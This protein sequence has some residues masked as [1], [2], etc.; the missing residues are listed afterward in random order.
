[1]LGRIG[2]GV[3]LALS[4]ILIFIL[5]GC[6][7]SAS[8]TSAVVV[9]PTETA[10]P[11]ATAT[12][13]PTELPTATPTPAP[14]K[15]VF[16]VDA[17]KDLGPISKLVLGTNH[18]PWSDLGVGNLDPA[19]ASGITF[20]RWPGGNWGDRNDVVPYMIDGFMFQAHLM[21]AEP[22][23]VVRLPNNTPEK[24]AA[25]VGYVNIE[26]QYGVKY[27]SIG[28][29]P[30]LYESDLAMKALNYNAVTAAQQW[31][32]FAVAMKK[33]D[34]TIKL[35]GPDIHQ[36][37][38]DPNFDP[39]DKDGRSYLLEFLKINADLVDIVTVHRYPFPACQSC[40]NPTL[41]QLRDN[42]PEWEDIIPNLKRIVKETTGK[43]LPV[44]VTEFNSNY[45]NSAGGATT[46]D[47]IAGAV[48]TADVLGRMIRHQPEILAYWTLKTNETGF[49]LMS[50][51]DL[52]PS[53][54][55]YQLYKQFGSHLLPTNSDEQYVSVFAAKRDDGA[56][57]VILVNRGDAA[58]SKPVQ[59]DGVGD[60]QLSGA[61]LLDATHSAEQFAM[62]DFKNGSPVN[63]P[64]ESVTL[65]VISPVK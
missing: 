32:D 59:I 21:G 62:N 57:T 39:K 44:G 30:S 12:P 6:Q 35:Y 11:T 34:P 61:Y 58:V 17:A 1:M 64:A 2:A 14:P 27:W 19:K 65:L 60:V 45:A 10:A 63:L 38:G 37:K 28:N 20:L 9:Q 31:H 56:V 46:P 43:D 55:V 48:W 16:W 5:I 29:E 18:G 25:L 40:G 23:I 42:T 7:P 49:G 41:Q 4:F 47:S 51:Y 33:V 8:P 13:A 24:A 22:S 54:Y 53:Y 15:G 36:F 26:K 3:N 52:R 50:A